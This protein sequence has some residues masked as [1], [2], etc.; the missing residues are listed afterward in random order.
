MA[1]SHRH[2]VS[3]MP[4]LAGIGLRAPHHDQLLAERPAIGFV[5]VHSENYFAPGS[6]P[7]RS[8]EA[9]RAHYPVSLHGVGLSLGSD[10]PLA[11]HLRRLVELVRHIE[12]ALVS[13]HLCWCAAGDVHLNELLPLPYTEEALDRVVAR[14]GAVQDAL[15]RQILIENVSSYLEYSH[16]TIAEAEFL[17]AV[18]ER[19]DCGI[20][21]DVNN[22]HVSACNHGWDALAYLN[23]IPAGRVWQ[24]HLAGHQRRNIDGTTLCIDTHDR[25]VAPAVWDLFEA[26]LARLG[27]RPTL[28][29][30][31]AELPPLATLCDQADQA[32][33]RL[34][35]HL[36]EQRA[37]A[38]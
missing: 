13:D 6:P 32:Q 3:P 23:A 9:A 5:E 12:P 19:A 1:A 35:P 17:G 37:V 22:I 18:A 38:G 10:T 21:L 15:G 30:W 29:E 14:I 16:S 24:L 7:Q 34:D 25:P 31:D 11:D 20:L 4:A 36:G 28:I 33:R 27:P 26:T 8:L 2:G